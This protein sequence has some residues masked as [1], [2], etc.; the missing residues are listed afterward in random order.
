MHMR[1]LSQIIKLRGGVD[2]I[3]NSGGLY[4]FLEM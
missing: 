1:G 3:G 4:M 2:K